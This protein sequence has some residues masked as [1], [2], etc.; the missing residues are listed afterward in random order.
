MANKKLEPVAAGI[1]DMDSAT[2]IVFDHPLDGD[3]AL[4]TFPQSPV[5][6]GIA[7]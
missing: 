3:T 7:V 6:G 1:L 5:E 4:F 2:R